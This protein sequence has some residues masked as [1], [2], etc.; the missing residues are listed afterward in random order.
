MCPRL[1]HSTCPWVPTPGPTWGDVTSYPM[2]VGSR[3]ETSR[4]VGGVN[5]GSCAVGTR[6]GRRSGVGSAGWVIGSPWSRSVG[7]FSGCRD[8]WTTS[9]SSIQR[10]DGRNNLRHWGQ[11]R[12]LPLVLNSRWGEEQITSNWR[13][14]QNT[15]HSDLSVGN[16]YL[17]EKN[18]LV[19]RTRDDWK[20]Y[21]PFL[22]RGLRH[23][24]LESLS[25]DH[26]FP[27]N[28]PERI[29]TRTHRLWD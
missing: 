20:I 7:S 6:Y 3:Y 17:Y 5:N 18:F 15:K 1:V 22:R 14:S 27:T 28:I 24:L 25:W 16:D 11:D 2:G 10:P 9:G 21:H 13:L 4:T 26:P 29:V 23:V 8:G 12:P 19:V